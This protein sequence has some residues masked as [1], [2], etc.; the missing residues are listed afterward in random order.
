[1]RSRGAQRRA[2]EAI[3]SALETSAPRLTEMFAMFTR[4]TADEEPVG[5]ERL[6]PRRHDLR[7]S[8]VLVLPVA[9]LIMLIVCLVLGI[10]AGGA[11][12]C[13]PTAHAHPTSCAIPARK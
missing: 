4:L 7:Q 1:V 9:A 8:F 3:E 13:V 6:A 2:L 12:A 5:A 10:T 11:S